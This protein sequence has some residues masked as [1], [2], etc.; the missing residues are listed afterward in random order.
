MR[1]TVQSWFARG[2]IT[3]RAFTI[4]MRE[5]FL[6]PAASARIQN[7]SHT[8]RHHW[9]LGSNSERVLKYVHCPV[10]IVH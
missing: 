8:I 5:I 10:V 1:M 3:P 7:H 4:R 2:A 6:P 9:M